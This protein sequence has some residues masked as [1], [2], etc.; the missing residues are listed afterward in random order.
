MFYG[1]KQ[2]LYELNKRYEKGNFEC[3]VVYGRRRVGKTALINEFCKDKDTIYFSALDTTAKENLDAFSKA[4]FV[5]QN[6]NAIQAPAFQTKIF[7]RVFR[8]VRSCQ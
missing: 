4:I 1:R 2:E 8:Q 3:I 6:P 5:N 7:L